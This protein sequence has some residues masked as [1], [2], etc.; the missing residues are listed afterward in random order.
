MRIN[1][2]KEL[3]TRLLLVVSLLFGVVVLTGPAAQAQGRYWYRYGGQRGRV[4]IY[5]QVYPRRW[6]GYNGAYPYYQS[7]Y[8]FPSTR[9]TE[10]QGYH[11]GLHDGK[12]DAEDGKGYNPERHSDY[13]NAQT[14][15]YING[16]LEGYAQGYDRGED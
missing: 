5:P 8:Y 1:R 2:V 14:S 13:K 15:G 7:Y 10:D 6:Y 3:V 16:Y 4:F 12:G 11:D 9:V